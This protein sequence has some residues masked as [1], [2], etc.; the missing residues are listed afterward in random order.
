MRKILI[1]SL[2]I[3]N[4]QAGFAQFWSANGSNI[5]NTNTG[6]IGI[7]TS[8]PSSTYKL[9]IFGPAV[10]IRTNNAPAPAYLELDASGVRGVFESIISPSSY[11]R[12]GTRG[13]YKF[14]LFTNNADRLTVTTNG[15][16]G[17]GNTNPAYQL[18]VAGAIN[19][20]SIYINGAPFAGGG[21]QWTTSGSSI[22]YIPG[23]GGSVGI[24][25][26]TPNASYKL[27]VAG[28]I[29]VG[30]LYVNG[31]QLSSA[32]LW[33]MNGS[34]ISYTVGKVSIGTTT[35]GSYMLAVAGKVAANSEVRVFDINTTT[36]PD[37]VFDPSYELPSLEQTEK[38]IK[39]YRHLPEVPSAQEIG[40]DGMSLNE[41]NI[42]LLKKVEELTLHLIALKKENE[43]LN[44]RLTTLEK[45]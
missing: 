1:L 7:G 31:Q 15:F 40:R 13:N 18:D 2:I 34:N 11:T 35:P 29:N 21:S 14:A 42:I 36:F 30:S 25:T 19:A 39:E 22:Y 41:M 9:D 6:V 37:Y 26:S 43:N 28:A 3:A 38:Y 20:S 12:V 27:D 23:G 8:T 45:K 17:I 16:V 33:S 5:Y 4:F 44:S 24:G 10:R 32:A